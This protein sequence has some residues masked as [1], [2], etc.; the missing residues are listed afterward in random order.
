[1]HAIV[2][3]RHVVAILFA[4]CRSTSMPF[5]VLHHCAAM[6]HDATHGG[7]FYLASYFAAGRYGTG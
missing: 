7:I 1:M 2:K 3:G 4:W 5:V 6:H